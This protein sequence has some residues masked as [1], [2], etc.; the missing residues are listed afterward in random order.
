MISTTISSGIA[1]TSPFIDLP[2]PL[3]AI[4]YKKGYI[5]RKCC[6]DSNG[7][8]SK[9]DFFSGCL[10]FIILYS[11]YNVQLQSVNV[12]GNYSMQHYVI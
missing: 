7:R 12:A 11:L 1:T 9:F 8:R 3:V 4:E 6:Y 2:N 10:I 5:R